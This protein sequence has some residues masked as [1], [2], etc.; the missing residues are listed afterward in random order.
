MSPLHIIYT[1]MALLD[2]QRNVELVS[3]KV[4]AL[5]NDTVR[6][7]E[8]MREIERLLLEQQREVE[9]HRELSLQ[10]RT[11]LVTIQ[12]VEQ[13]A[14]ESVRSAEMGTRLATET[15][16][17]LETALATSQAR[18]RDCNQLLIAVREE[19]ARNMM[20]RDQEE[21]ELHVC[22][23]KEA[24]KVTL[25][26]EASKACDAQHEHAQALEKENLEH[27]VRRRQTEEK[28]RPLLEQEVRLRLQRQNLEA[29]E[30]R[31]RDEHRSFHSTTGRAQTPSVP[32]A[33]YNIHTAAVAPSL[34]QLNTEYHTSPMRGYYH[35]ATSQLTPIP[36]SSVTGSPARRGLS[37]HIRRS[38]PPTSPRV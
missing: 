36:P 28:E 29:E 15:L 24:V 22:K 1:Q 17:Q 14:C 38:S 20:A 21:Q 23:E 6:A 8:R 7:E 5:E 18:E 3:N 26:A 33:G 34:R 31:L 12:T 16:H 11:E 4:R 37:P 2:A 35:S 9:R 30:A 25:E 27:N 19:L 10:A 13:Q 32:T